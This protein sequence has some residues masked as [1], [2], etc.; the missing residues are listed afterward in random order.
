MALRSNRRPA[1]VGTLGV[2]FAWVVSLAVSMTILVWPEEALASQTCGVT[3]TQTVCVTVPDA[4]LTGPQLIGVTNSPNSGRLTFTWVPSG[5][6]ATYLITKYAP[7]PETGDYSF[8]WPTQKYLDGSGKLKVKAPGATTAVVVPVTLANGNITDIQHTANDWQ[9]HLPGAWTR[10]TDP[11]VPA[12]G[13]GPSD[14]VASN[15]VA[16]MITAFGPPL[17]L[18]LGDIYNKGT[19]TENLNHYGVS[20]LDV[21]GGGTLWGE[22]ADVTQPAL[23]NHEAGHTADWVDYWHQRP[24]YTKFT[25]GGVLFL[26]LNSSASFTAGSDQYTFVQDALAT[27]PACVVAFWHI[28]VVKNTTINTSLQPMWSLLA[29]NGGDLVLNGHVH[30]MSEYVPLD[31]NL[32]PGGHMVQLISGAGGHSLGG[33]R[34][35]PLIAFAKGKT[36]GA[37]F[38]TL[39]GAASGGTATG[40]DWAFEDTTGTVL[41]TGSVTC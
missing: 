8:T 41:R 10:S 30:N 17:F 38:L 14:E 21:P 1:T 35:G 12:V 40:I 26:D 31:A 9:S 32:Q 23:G 20:A 16:S 33:G 28:P 36:P 39:K 34:T 5:G 3:G 6:S 18:F 37:L 19:F 4:P 29:S 15:S 22:F 27:A 13:D 24:T 25:F 11:V 2:M 7:S